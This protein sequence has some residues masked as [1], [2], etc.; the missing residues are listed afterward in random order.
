VVL[1]R[2]LTPDDADALLELRLR[3][4]DFLRPL[5]PIRP[6]GF[7]T[8]A[9][10]RADLEWAL[11]QRKA[12]LAYAFG[13]FEAETGAMAGR[14]ALSNIV[15]GAWRNCTV[16]YYVDQE[17]NGRGY[18]T[19][20]LGLATGFALSHAGLHR[21]QAGVMPRNAASIRVVEKNGFRFEGQARRYLQINGVWEDHNIYAVTAEDW[22][23]SGHASI[24]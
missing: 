3:N 17:R 22:P 1:L 12:G 24:H 8:P 9:S 6:D 5:E 4:Q 7:L 14:I 16:G 2:E 13:I 21:V 20:A 10:Q 11:G 23:S 18:A 19:E 15:R